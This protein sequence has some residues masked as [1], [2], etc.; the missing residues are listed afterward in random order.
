MPF[1]SRQMLIISSQILQ[2]DKKFTKYYRFCVFFERIEGFIVRE[3]GQRI[4][5]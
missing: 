2:K 3:H 5:E 1:L 4:A